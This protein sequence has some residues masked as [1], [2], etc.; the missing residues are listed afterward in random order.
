[1]AA[2]A[3]RT[4][5]PPAPVVKAGSVELYKVEATGDPRVGSTL[6]AKA[7]ESAYA[8]VPGSAIVDY[9]WQYAE[10]ST[11]S[12]SAFKDIP[13]ATGATYTIGETIDGAPAT[14][15]Y[16]RVKATS[17]GTVVSTKQPSHYGST[18][19]D[20]LGPIMLE[21][22][23]ELSSVKL[24]SSGQGMQAGNTITP[25]AQVK[26]GYYESAAPADA[27]VAYAWEVRDG[28]GGAFEPLEEGV[29]PDGAL[30]L[31]PALVGKQVRVSA[32]ALVEGNNPR[33][34]ACTVLA[35]G[36]YDL[37]RVTLSPPRATC[38]PVTRS[39]PG[40]RPEAWRALPTATTCPTT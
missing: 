12:D 1:M 16:V 23:Y 2:T 6:S 21:G 14:G 13:G 26:D 37:L 10:T 32:N 36:E 22:A 35:A 8:Q 17:D 31:S 34:A 9:Q 30:T 40:S 5:P 29:A 7:Y 19:V 20:P 15:R 18:Y 24:A 27:K 33:S 3:R 39:R 38:S 11:T 28:E 25:T 4:P